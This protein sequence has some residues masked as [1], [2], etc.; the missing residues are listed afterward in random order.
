VIFGAS[1]DLTH[2]KLLPTLAHLDHKHPLPPA[3]AI[4]GLA[5]RPMDDESFRQ[6]ALKALDTFVDEGPLDDQARQ[7][8]AWRLY[9]HRA[10]FTDPA[11]YTSL[12]QRLEEIDHERGGTG[13]RVFYL[14]TPPSDYTRIIAQLG[15]AGLNREARDGARG[16]SKV[17][18]EKPFGRDLASAQALNAE[19]GEIFRESQIYR[20]DHYLGK[21]TVQNLLAFR[22]GN[23]IFEPLWNQK[24]ID[25]VQILVAESLGVG[26]RGGYYEEAGAIRDMVQNHMMQLL[27]LTGMEPPVAFDAESVRD[28][29]VKLLR[30]IRPLTTHEVRER[31]VR[32]QY[33]AGQVDGTQIPDYRQEPNVAADSLTETYVALKLFIENWRWAGVPFYL[34]TGKALPKRSTEITIHFKQ[35]PY[36]L[37]AGEGE[38]RSP[39]VLTVRVQPDEGIALQFGA[40]EPG[41]RMTLAPVNMDF[42]YK[43]SFGAETP[44]AYERLIVDC[45]LGDSTLFIRRD[46]V[47]GAWKVVD[48][49]VAGWQESRRHSLP[50]YKA[51]AWGPDEADELIRRDGRQWWNP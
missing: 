47:E 18:I 50:T 25:H 43:Y 37:F 8:F 46:E 39:N 27:C 32:A 28:E 16:W 29:K 15:A 14:A 31:A 51:G 10:D 34:R 6:D 24:Y 49:I 48:S 45:M 7:S 2:R 9:Y 38:E 1:G 3:T 11:G 35:A 36:L 5:R 4:V 13:N 19:I 12:A 26:S 44:E 41:P 42:S 23:G 17:V 21:E 30:S 33:S 22:F 20:I 40:K